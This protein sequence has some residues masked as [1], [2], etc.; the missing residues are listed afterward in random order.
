MGSEKDGRAK[1][2]SKHKGAGKRAT[3]QKM[4]SK[5]KLSRFGKERKKGEAGIASA[6]VT[7]TQVLKRLQLTLKDFRRLCILKGV[8][9]RDPRKN[10]KAGKHKTYYHYK[11][12]AHLSHEP[13]IAKFREFKAFMK[14]VRKTLGRKDVAGAKRKYLDAPT[15]T[16]HHLVKERYP[17]F[18]D[19]L[20]DLDDALN[21]VHMFAALP[22]KGRV[23]AERTASCRELVAQWQFYLIQSQPASLAK[24][25]ISVKGVYLQATV[26]GVEVTWINPHEYTQRVPSDVDFRTMMTFLEFYET[27]LKFTLFKLY[28]SRG[29]QYPPLPSGGEGEGSTNST[30][31]GFAARGRLL[32]LHARQLDEGSDEE[33][34]EGGDGDDGDVKAAAVA[35]AVE[36]A[37]AA[38]KAKAKGAA[39]RAKQVRKRLAASAEAGGDDDDEE[40]E[41][42]EEAGEGSG[43]EDG[44]KDDDEREGDGRLNPALSRE[45]VHRQ[46]EE[47]LVSATTANTAGALAGGGGGEEAEGAAPKLLEGLAFFLSRESQYTWLEFVI[48]AFGG[49]VG[50]GGSEELGSVDDPS[51]THVV[52][53]RPT[54]PQMTR[55]DVEWVQP[56]WVVDSI[57]A[58]LLLPVARYAPGATL[59]PH[60]SPF[61][62]DA[63]EG[64]VPQYRKELDSLKS[65]AEEY[66]NLADSAPLDTAE[67][68]ASEAE[69][70]AD[71]EEDAA[72]EDGDEEE[73]DEEEEEEGGDREEEDEEEDE[74]EDGSGKKPVSEEKALAL[75]MMGKKAKRLY[76]RMQHGINK[77][78]GAVEG[79][80]RKAAAAA[81]SEEGSAS[82]VKK[83]AAKQK[84]PKKKGGKAV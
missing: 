4:G 37:S 52:Y 43:D 26:S 47:A 79:L 5:R 19:A 24:V 41:E 64:Y 7:R 9:P 59:P 44:G 29:L 82:E 62:N 1:L 22:S 25:F 16:L 18:E 48:L 6:F 32:S 61:V 84:Q 23:T 83:M 74:D 21:L 66:G 75:V 65:A 35:A 20:R 50:W 77:K 55:A 60:L 27:L 13:L 58:G 8:Y 30:D 76:D 56:Q 15:Y 45:E 69:K 17:K 49:K 71:E 42:E 12:V 31:G 14:K 81:A 70:A 67:A 57:N 63:K 11:D 46:L 33:D 73:E 36:K 40:E 68:A 3:V 53:D 38:S 10:L 51:V 54:A 28:H 78:S 80:K 34:Q 72:A 39:K 2:K